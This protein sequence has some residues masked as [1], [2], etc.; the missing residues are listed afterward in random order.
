MVLPGLETVASD[1]IRRQLDADVTRSA[2]GMVVFRPR[3]IDHALLSL[4]TT[5]DVFVLAWGT[6]ELTYRAVDLDSIRRWTERSVAWDKLLRIHHAIRPK[7]KGKP[8]YRLVVQMHGK[9]GYRRVDA[10]KALVRGLGGKL[11]ASWRHA[12]ENASVEIWLTIHGATAVCGLRLSD[13][14]M[15]HRT[16][17]EAHQPASLRPTLAAAMVQLAEIPASGGRKPPDATPDATDQ[18]AYTLRSPLVLDPFCGAGT[19]LAEVFAFTRKAPLT[20]IGGD[21]DASALRAAAANLRGVGQVQLLRADAR[22]LPLPGNSVDRVI[23]NPPFGIQLGKPED[24]GSLYRDMASELDRVLK[25]GGRA[26]LLVADD[27]AM[28]NAAR[29]V[30]WRHERSVRVRLLGQR[31][32]IFV[33]RS[34]GAT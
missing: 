16:Y 13:R 6:N 10:R 19:I 24:I 23:S 22:G 3:E 25:P 34:A 5:E 15:R 8:T 20:V 2:P 1:E 32:T 30:G 21:V 17:K 12:D 28:R 33:F 14:S 11:P 31:A 7:P 18:G 29:Q 9:H 27:E 26:V 4:R